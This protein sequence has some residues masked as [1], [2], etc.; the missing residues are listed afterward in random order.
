MGVRLGILRLAAGLAILSAGQADATEVKLTYLQGLIPNTVEPVSAEG[1]TLMGEQVNNF[2][3]G[4]SFLHTDVSLPGVAGLRVELSRRHTAGRTVFTRGEL[5]D[6]DLEL[7]RMTGTYTTNLGWVAQ[8][9]TARCSQFS[10]PATAIGHYYD[11]RKEKFE[12]WHWDAGQFWNGV[13]L[14]VPGG[15]SEEVGVR[16]ASNPHQAQN[17]GH[18]PLTTKS[19]WQIGCLPS[20][21]NS[22]GEGFVAISPDGVTYRFDWMSRRHTNP[23]RAGPVALGRADYSLLATRVTDRFGNWVSYRY[24]GSA[25]ARLEAITSSDGREIRVTWNAQGRVEQVTDGVRVWTY[26]YSSQGDLAQVTRPDGT[27]WQFN[28]RPLVHPTPQELGEHANCDKPGFFPDQLYAGRITHPTGAVGIFKMR[29]QRFDRQNVNRLCRVEQI[30]SNT[31]EPYYTKETSAYWPR[32]KVSLALVSKKLAGPGLPAMPDP[33]PGH[34]TLGEPEPAGMSW[35][36]TY[37]GPGASWASS[38]PCTGTRQTTITAPD[39][40]QTRHTFGICFRQDEGQLLRTEEGLSAA[41]ALRT[42]E[43]RYR[44]PLSGEFP[45]PAA[46]VYNWNGDHLSM[47]LRPQDRKLITQQN[48]QFLW[49]AAGGTEGFDT[50]GRPTKA[51]HGSSQGHGKWLTTEYAHHPA[52]WVLGPVASVR[53]HL[54]HVVEQTVFDGATALPS[55]FHQFGRLVQTYSHWPDGQLWK[56]I[57]PAGRATSWSNYHRGQAQL[58]SHRDTVQEAAAINHL[59]KPDSYTNAAGTTTRYGY[60][61]LGRLTRISFPAEA[62]GAYHDMVVGYTPSASAA[63]GLE[64]GFWTQ[65]LTHGRAQTVHVLDALW[66]VRMTRTWDLDD[67]ANTRTVTIYRYDHDNRKTFQSYPQREIADVN[68]TVPGTQWVFD[69]LGREVLE[70]QDSEH[71]P[72]D[73]VTTYLAGFEKR[74]TNARQIAT[75][76]GYQAFDT[77]TEDTLWYARLPEGVSLRIDRDIH[78]K[79]LAITRG[80]NGLSHTRQYVYDNHHR[81]CKTI[82]PEAGATVQ[83]YDANNNIAWRAT[84]LAQPSITQC[85]RTAPGIDA[86][87]IVHGYDVRDRLTTLTPA[88]GSQATR[89]TYT[90]DSLPESVQT[91]GGGRPTVTWSYA[92]NN[93]RL[94]TAENFNWGDPASWWHFRRDW[95]ASGH[96]LRQHDPWGAMDLN[97]NALGQARSVGNYATQVRYHPNGQL[98]SYMAGNGVAFTTELNVRGLPTLWQHAGTVQDRY[99]YDANGNVTG[100]SDE[101]QGQHRSMPWYDGLDRLRQANGPWGAGSFSYD[102]LDNITTSSVGSRNVVMR[103]DAQNRLEHL[104]GSL[105]IGIGY[106]ANGN[107]NR[108]GT[109]DYV[110]DLANRMKQASGRGDY[111]YDGHGRRALMSPVGGGLTIQAYTQ[112]GKLS[113]G[114]KTGEGGKRHVYLGSHL[115]AELRDT[116]EVTYSHTDALGSPVVRTTAS[117]TIVSRTRYEPYGGTVAGSDAPRGIGYT[118]HVQDLDTGLVY[119]QQRYYDPVAGRFL[120]VDPVVTD[121]KAGDHFNRYVYAENNPFTLVDPD[122]RTAGNPYKF[123]HQPGGPSVGGGGSGRGGVETGGTGGGSGAGGP[124]GRGQTAMQRGLESEARVLRDIGQTKNTQPVEAGGKR[125]IPDFQ[126]SRQVGE[127]KDTKRVT[128]SAQLKT[129]RAA[130]Q[131]SGRE[132]IVVTGTNTKVSSTVQNNSTVVRRDDLG[133]KETAK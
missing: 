17:G 62:T 7:P 59:G 91:F 82:E 101:L 74:V 104:G 13:F 93:R 14:Q 87:K 51:Y 126:N 33:E 49:E 15:S 112:D 2:D 67:E 52:L 78:G 37:A 100:I 30:T 97:P 69:A 31:G 3:G 4:L 28:L 98:A 130:A 94:L 41:G 107:L 85:D 102:A 63:Y 111:T 10:A 61:P 113:F 115:I 110:F 103:Y 81:L 65:T 120:T 5:G 8:Q 71:G 6:W 42:T 36:Y 92:Y 20:T 83:D 48:T 84:G 40:A 118:G 86:R 50:F 117:R 34:S 76:Y 21:Q 70:R 73:T 44:V 96:L 121:A 60:D 77:P 57:D 127:I 109:A 39:G 38:T 105:D 54:G 22:T 129:E 72:L 12:H 123:P 27:R 68:A 88:D 18:Y 46:S 124:A 79:A 24:S 75:D 90:P 128:D 80:G 58:F 133:P 64:A 116:G 11:W 43:Y 35:R 114:W 23:L 53:D 19:F 9:S 25:P 125:A 99:T 132:H 45:E 119:M 56:A 106:D 29:Y 55:A 122:G 16:H 32:S 108:R 89:K 131:A 95:D 66:R 26:S 1:P 47:R